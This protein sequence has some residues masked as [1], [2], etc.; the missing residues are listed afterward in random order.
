MIHQNARRIGLA[1]V[2][3][4]LA[5]CDAGALAQAPPREAR[6]EVM[7]TMKRATTFMTEKLA[8]RAATSGPTCPISRGGGAK[9]KRARR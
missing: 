9:S 1:A 3:T 6:D 2:L 4:A 5:L 7:A 8:T